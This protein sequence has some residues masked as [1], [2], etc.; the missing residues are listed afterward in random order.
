ME[1]FL[2]FLSQHVIAVQG[3]Y[4]VCMFILYPAT[5]L[6][7]FIR[8]KNFLVESLDSIIERIKSSENNILTSFLFF[9][10]IKTIFTL[11][12]PLF[13]LQQLLQCQL[14]HKFIKSSLLLLHRETDRCKGTQ[15]SRQARQASKASRQEDRQFCASM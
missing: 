7:M 8:F 2:W 15:I 14:S 3:N 6:I 12:P 9:S 5:L 1:L 4:W 10:S 13:Y 11:F